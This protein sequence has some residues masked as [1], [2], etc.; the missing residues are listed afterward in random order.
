MENGKTFQA[1]ERE[2][3]IRNYSRTTI[4]SYLY[5]NEEILRFFQK[6]SHH[7]TMEYIKSYL[8]YTQECLRFARVG[9]SEITSKIVRD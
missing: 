3:R 9:A 4:K 6:D 5:Y 1:L 7:I 8:Y 2:L